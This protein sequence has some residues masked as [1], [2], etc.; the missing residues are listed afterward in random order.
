MLPSLELAS[1]SL[2]ERQTKIR[3]P[4]ISRMKRPLRLVY[5][6]LLGAGRRIGRPHKTNGL[7]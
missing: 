4:T 3:M 2:A 6:K 1:R 5:F 7:E